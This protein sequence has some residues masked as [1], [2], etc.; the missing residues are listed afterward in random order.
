V[1]AQP[2]R[3]DADTMEGWL[4]EYCARSGPIHVHERVGSTND[5]AREAL[6]GTAPEWTVIAA[7]TQA[8]G[9]G[10]RGRAWVSPAGVN[11]YLSVTTPA[12]GDRRDWPRLPILAGAAASQA[13]A[14]LGGRVGVKWPNDLLASD[15]GKVGG[16]LV[17][18]GPGAAGQAIFGIGINVNAEAAELPAGGASLRAASDAPWD[19][20]RLAA[21]L[22]AELMAGWATLERQGFAPIQ[23]SWMERACWLDRPVMVKGDT[24][25]WAGR[26]A[27]IDEW[28]R[29]RLATPQGE[30]VVSA[31]DVSLRPGRGVDWGV[32]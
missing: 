3:L 1:V 26:L 22:V 4:A 23:R 13:I 5:L 15:G 6:A 29:L 21:A 32:D 30:R 10:R 25:T 9:R 16:I 24:V 12:V 11:L 2:D 19:R 18:A 8:A 20:N 17:E 7:E 28:G 14:G 31:G 27:G